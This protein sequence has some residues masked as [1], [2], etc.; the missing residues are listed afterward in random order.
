[1][2]HLEPCGVVGRVMPEEGK[3][4]VPPLQNSTQLKSF[5][6]LAMAP[7]WPGRLSAPGAQSR[8]SPRAQ[9][10]HKA[11]DSFVSLWAFIK[12]PLFTAAGP[13][14]PHPQAG[15]SDPALCSSCVRHLLLP[16][17]PLR[18]VLWWKGRA[19]CRNCP[20]AADRAQEPGMTAPKGRRH[21]CSLAPRVMLCLKETTPLPIV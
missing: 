4:V 15:I 11:L 18:P 20:A 12:F 19:V 3:P 5:L 17:G 9:H 1:M 8:S 7:L 21:S 2:A 16:P 13:V 14:Q 10:R 6:C